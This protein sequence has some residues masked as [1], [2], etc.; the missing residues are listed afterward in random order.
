VKVGGINLQHPAGTASMGTVVDTEF[1]VKGVK[2]LRVVNAS[3]IPTP[4]SAPIQALVY[5]LGERAV[6]LI[7]KESFSER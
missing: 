4:I 5:A 7:M 3:V 1:R 6:E 2:G